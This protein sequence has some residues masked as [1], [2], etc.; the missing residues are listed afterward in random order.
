MQVQGQGARLVLRHSVCTLEVGEAVGELQLLHASSGALLTL[1]T[2]VLTLTSAKPSRP[3]ARSVSGSSS[4]SSSGAPGGQGQGREDG[5]PEVCMLKSLSG[6]KLVAKDS[7]LRSDLPET[8]SPGCILYSSTA[9]LKGCKLRG[10]RMVLGD[11]GWSG[12]VQNSS[13]L[14]MR[15]CECLMPPSHEQ[16]GL[17][18]S[19]AGKAS[20]IRCSLDGEVQ[21]SS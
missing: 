5:A 18:L 1:D 16:A 17:R 12:G 13:L 15:D 19:G 11:S 3:G 6:A 9:L 21:V 8:A 20:L 4:S 10:F 7:L 14:D 2:A